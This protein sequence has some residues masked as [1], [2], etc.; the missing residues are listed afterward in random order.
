MTLLN[1]VLITFL[2]TTVS[3][4]LLIF[5]L[6]A[7]KSLGH[8]YPM[9]LMRCLNS[10]AVYQEEQF[11]GRHSVVVPYELP[12]LDGCSFALHCKFMC[13]SSCPG[14]INRRP[15]QLVITLEHKYDSFEVNIYFLK[16]N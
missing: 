11:N 1:D 6:I 14:G 10:R 15:T 5:Q 16:I 4:V 12:T 9:H 13:F 8:E 3:L 2:K 7:F